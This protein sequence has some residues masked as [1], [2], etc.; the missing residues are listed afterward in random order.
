M[1]QFKAV[2][3]LN[4]EDFERYQW[5]EI[6][7][8]VNPNE[9][10]NYYDKFQTKAKAYQLSGDTL[11]EEIFK[12]L[13]EITSVFMEPFG[14]NST[15]TLEE[16]ILPETMLGVLSDD[17]LALLRELVVRV[18]EPE[19]RARIADILWICKRDP[20]RSRPI[21]MAKVAVESYLQAAKNLENTENQKPCHERLQRAAQLAPL[22]DGK[23]STEMRCLVISHI[24]QL[25][26]RYAVVEN[27]FIT[28]SAMQVLQEDLRKSLSVIKSNN[29]P[30]YAAKYAAV[31]AQKAVF[32]EN[33]QDYHKAFFQKIA[34]RLIESE[35]YKI[36]NDKE[37]ERNARFNLAEVEVWYAQQ[38]LVRNEPNS[39][40]VAAGRLENAIAVFRKIEDT[41]GKK[42]DTSDRIQDLHKQMLENQRVSMSLMVTI[43]IAKPQKFDDP[44]MQKVARDIVRGKPLRDA[45]YSLAFGCKLIRAL[46]DIQVEAKADKSS[47]L[48]PRAFIDEEGKTKAISGDGEESLEN[49]MF[50][51]AT[52]Y[53]S[54]YALNFIVPACNQICSEHSVHL[55]DLSFVVV[56]NPFIPKG[57][58]A[59]YA[60]GL[61][62][63]LQGDIV[64]AA[65]LLIPQL[66]NSLR[67][68]LKQNDFITSHLTSAMIQDDYTLNK[69]LDLSDLKQVLNENIIFTLKGLLVERMGSNLRNEICHGLFSHNQFFK[70]Q[71]AYLWWLTLYLCLLVPTYRQ[72]VEN[73]DQ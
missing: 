17:Q 32:A 72:C 59:L 23:K 55:E 46:A 29:L 42:Q 62:A 58:E 13:S 54:W 2:P 65:H 67:H 12:F 3:L 73:E 35:W 70:P 50:R 19:M 57:R 41:F 71:L 4:A 61:L 38:A 31:A 25:I 48:I 34:Y 51:I 44:E 15:S 53:Q 5:T 6:L 36:A 22:V 14:L 37:A 7:D 63:G 30:I 28:G 40:I 47:H 10:W 64:I 21:Q 11:G 39:Y 66:E 33:F 24:E 43:P 27:E 45:L 16:T 69:V 8:R 68:I 49:S 60:R 1:S 20:E 18:I 56:E 26:E 52:F 9:C